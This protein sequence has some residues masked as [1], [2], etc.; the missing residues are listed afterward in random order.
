MTIYQP[1]T[2]WCAFICNTWIT[3]R[4]VGGGRA[5][6]RFIEF[7]FVLCIPLVNYTAQYVFRCTRH[8]I[9]DKKTS[10]ENGTCYILDCRIFLKVW[11]LPLTMKQLYM[12]LIPSADNKFLV[13]CLGLQ[14]LLSGV[15]KG[16]LM[17]FFWR[18]G[19]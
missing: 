4:F 9:V 11:S 2:A 13:I 3:Y 1:I 15:E 8:V 16:S 5:K 14:V 17:W 7:H 18:G 12:S 10:K 19:G 6:G